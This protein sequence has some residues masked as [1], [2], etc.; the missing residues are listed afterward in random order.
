MGTLSRDDLFFFF[1]SVPSFF[2]S[3]PHFLYPYSLFFPS[4]LLFMGNFSSA[5]HTPG[6]VLGSLDA[7]G[8][9][10]TVSLFSWSSQSNEGEKL[11][12]DYTNQYAIISIITTE[13][14]I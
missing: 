6:P 4:S 11:T 13:K 2:P 9:E 5:S 8:S 14:K 12:K 7:M 3:L 10:T 1:H